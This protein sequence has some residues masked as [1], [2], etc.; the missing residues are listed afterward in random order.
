[1][2]RVCH[3]NTCPVGIATQ[4][5]LLRQRF[6]GRPEHVIRF[7]HF[8][9]EDVRRHMARL[10]F[11]RFEDMIGRTD[12]LRVAPVA[13]RGKS[14]VL[15]LSPLLR[16]SGGEDAPRR[17]EGARPMTLADSVD[18]ELLD[19]CAAALE[20]AEP[21]RLRA[22]VRNVH[23]SIGAL[24]SGEVA[25]RHGAEGLPEGT[26]HI[27]LE[28]CAGQS[29]GA[30]LARGITLS[31]RGETNDYAG[32][33]L[34]GGTIVV[35]PIDTGRRAQSNIIAGNVALYGATSGEVYLRG[36]AGE[37]FAVRNSG[38]TAVVEGVGDHGCEYMTGGTVVIIGRTGR[39]FAAGMSGGTAYVFDEDGRFPER[40][41]ATSAELEELDGDEDVAL[42]RRLLERHLLLTDSDVAR[43]LLHAWRRTIARIV[44]VM[45]AEYREAVARRHAESQRLELVS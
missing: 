17:F 8:V 2:M 34:S 40:C 41:S 6:A 22:S 20:H 30:W 31:L 28:G 29:F 10:G 27:E 23:R 1:M 21:V 42:V 37:R 16:T 32:K 4:D 39:N 7:M 14:A 43:R 38:A 45:P 5:P 3:L 25:R 19:A 44:K 12:R 24:L 33:G 9:A 15:D 11:R 13:A 18:A 36:V 26:I 35:R